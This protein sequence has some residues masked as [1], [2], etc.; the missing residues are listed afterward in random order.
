MTLTKIEQMSEGKPFLRAFEVDLSS[1]VKI[2]SEI[3]SVHTKFNEEG[4]DS[5]QIDIE[6]V[7]QISDKQYE[8][9][10]PSPQERK[11]RVGSMIRTWF[12]SPT[13]FN[14]LI[15]TFGDQEK[16]WVNKEIELVTTEQDV[17][18]TLKKVIYVKG[19]K[20]LT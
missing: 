11:S 13:N 15:D 14:Y 19:A 6:L 16:D 7:T 18:G 5:M 20:A 12:V 1:K 9:M 8:V 2:T 10:I 4:E 17:F 3:R